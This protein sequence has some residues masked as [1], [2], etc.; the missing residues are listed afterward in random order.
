MKKILLIIFIFCLCFAN[1]YSQWTKCSN[2]LPT[3][4]SLRAFAITGNN[5][6]A[7]TNAGVYL[8]TN[9]GGTWTLDTNG[10]PGS[11][12]Y[13]AVKDSNIYVGN[14]EGIYL[15]TNY[16]ASWTFLN[17]AVDTI[18]SMFVKD[19]NIFIG[20]VHHGIYKSTNNGNIW[21]QN[22]N[23]LGYDTNGVYCFALYDTVIFVGSIDCIFSSTNNGNNWN[24]GYLGVTNCGVQALAIS[25]NNLYAATSPY[26]AFKS[27]DN[28]ST[29]TQINNGLTDPWDKWMFSMVQDGS[30]IYAGSIE[31]GAFLST[32]SG[33]SW[34]QIN[35]GLT[36]WEVF[37]LVIKDSIIFAGTG[38]GA[39]KANLNSIITFSIGTIN[40]II[41]AQDTSVQITLPITA[42]NSKI[43]QFAVSSDNTSLLPVD[44]LKIINHCDGQL[45]TISPV[46][47]QYGEANITVKVYKGGDTVSTTF[48]VIVLKNTFDFTI[49]GSDTNCQND[50]LNY[51]T[52]KEKYV[53]ITWR[54]VQG[55][56]I[57]PSND[58]T[59]KVLWNQSGTGTLVL[60]KQNVLGKKDS[61][62]KSI[63]INPIPPKPSITK[64]V[65]TLIS[66]ASQGNQ[67]FQDGNLISGATNNT[68]A[69]T[70]NGTYTVQVTLNGCP[71]PFS[72]GFNFILTNTDFTLSITGIDTTCQN[73]TLIYS[74]TKENS[75]TISWR[76]NNGNII[77]LNN[78][79]IVKV[80]WALAGTG[81][82]VLKKQN[83]LGR[84]DSSS[85]LITI[86]E[87][88]AKPT[89]TK[90]INILTSSSAE[91]NQWYRNDN[92][93]TGATG[94]SFSATQ[95]GKYKVQVTINGCQSP[96]SDALDFTYTGDFDFT[97]TGLDEVC[98]NDTIIYTALSEK[99]VTETWR[100]DNGIILGSNSDTTLKV[101]WDTAGI[102]DVV[103][104]K[105]NTS[106]GKKDSATITISIKELPPKPKVRKVF[107]TLISS[108][109]QGNQ[110]YKDG[111]LIN[112]AKGSTLNATVNGKYSVRVT[113]NGCP[114]PF[115][116]EFD[117]IYS[118]FDLTITGS[119]SA[120]QND[121]LKYDTPKETNVTISWN[122]NNGT[123][124]GSNDSSALKVLW[125]NIGFGN[126]IL[127]KENKSIR[128][129]ETDSIPV[130]IYVHPPKPTVTK[131]HN[132]LT[133]SAAEGN[134][135]YR[136]GKII[137]GATENTYTTLV[138]AKYSVVV[139]L[140]GC[141]SP[142][143]TEYNFVAGVEE[144][145]Y[146]NQFTIIPN[147]A[148]DKI[149]ISTNNANVI[150]TIEIYSLLGIRL[151][152]GAFDDSKAEID[153]RTFPV[154][155]YLVKIGEYRK[156]FVKN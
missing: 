50:T 119:Q 122:V 127:Q 7:G 61:V 111:I 142:P 91:G 99:N 138:N 55:N 120:C 60:K 152:Y 124:I 49:T 72:D 5:I 69:A 89:I 81:N 76:A 2:G 68:F 63:T 131:K 86:N 58:S 118:L 8:S 46:Y 140:D 31:R 66:S 22:N 17:S 155:I 11:R 139:T 107:N 141:S 101:L 34:T 85:K 156:I 92:P 10:I 115:S 39:Y 42:S 73:D 59:V 18:C 70:D 4:P 153:I 96:L 19:T 56:I 125:E 13:F 36:D 143:S 146:K 3:Y 149:Y 90:D 132:T 33:N 51:N 135:W 109:Y 93:I 37:S 47:G 57:G 114:S 67:W 112:G 110:W 6:L 64:N 35:N 27:T 154:G 144:E 145:N 32:N 78:D 48:K 106:L 38:S 26:G 12:P 102:G 53:T 95:D 45:M 128:K 71:S 52:V 134:Q 79:S 97:I 137:P 126:V 84:K 121:T 117:F 1:S 21:T 30:N 23:G 16:G 77:G 75:I 24:K 103:L 41:M 100:V 83:L 9:N 80:I 123:I 113:L 62:T 133:S 74:T 20:T 98:Q 148:N 116:D 29:W 14:Q 44:S 151:Y 87:I 94:Y 130:T 150:G 28:G 15:S 54:V 88:P 82:L 65:N 147:P 136:N 104:I 105:E 129:K 40:D 25:C 43:L 108:S